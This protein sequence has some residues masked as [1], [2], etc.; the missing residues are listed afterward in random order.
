MQTATTAHRTVSKTLNAVKKRNGFSIS[1]P[2]TAVKFAAGDSNAM[3]NSRGF[4][5]EISDD[6]FR[7]TT[8]AAGGF[9]NFTLDRSGCIV[10]ASRSVALIFIVSSNFSSNNTGS[11]SDESRPAK[12]ANEKTSIQKSKQHSQKLF[13]TYPQHGNGYSIQ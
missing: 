3:A 8:V 13:P 12:I 9:V 7:F 4:A 6:A 10:T 2:F 5:A 1:V 11:S